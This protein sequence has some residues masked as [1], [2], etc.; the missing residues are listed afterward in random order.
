MRH[1]YTKESAA[2][3]V[4]HQGDPTPTLTGYTYAHS[5]LALNTWRIDLKISAD[6]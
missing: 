1:T 5:M 3:V 6:S 2:N 4:V